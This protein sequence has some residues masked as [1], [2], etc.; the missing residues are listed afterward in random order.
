M[1]I[2]YYSNL[3]MLSG[4]YLL[5]AK[6]LERDRVLK[7]GMSMKLNNRLYDYCSVYKKPYYLYNYLINESKE[8]ILFLEKNI[9]DKTIDK[10][11]EDYSTEYRSY[12]DIKY[13]HNLICDT[14]N[15]YKIDFK[16]IENPQYE[17]EYN[18]L[19]ESLIREN[20]LTN[21]DKYLYER[22]NIQNQYI[23]A[24]LNILITKNKCLVKAPTGF[25]KTVLAFRMINEIKPN[26]SIIL[27]PRQLLNK[28]IQDDKYVK[29]LIDNYEFYNYSDNN[30]MRDQELNKFLE[31][32]GKKIIISCY[33]SIEQLYSIINNLQID[34]IIFDEAHTIDNWTN[35]E[36]E[37]KQYLL[38]SNAKKIFFTATPKDDMILNKNIYGQLIEKVKIYELINKEI[39]CNIKTV[40]KKFTH[41]S[42]EIDMYKFIIESMYKYNKKKGIIYVNSQNNAK[43]LYEQFNKINLIKSFI[44]IS[45]KYK[46]INIGDD[47][48]KEFEKYNQPC[49]IITCQKLSYG[50]DNDMIDLECFADPR[51]SPIEIRQ[52]IGRGI[53]W[54]KNTYPNKILHV[55]LPIYYDQFGKCKEFYTIK[56]YLDYIIGECGQEI[57]I[58]DS[59][60][61]E[62]SNG[63]KQLG[64]KSYEGDEIPPE[65]CEEYC[66]TA[67]N[68]F[69]KFMSFL[70]VN[71]GYNRERY[72]KLKEKF[73]WMI[74]LDKIFDKYPLFNFKMIHP[75]NNK[76]YQDKKE[77][78]EK[79]E[80]IRKELI[81]KYSNNF[82]KMK[83][84]SYIK[85]ITEQ[86]NMIPSDEIELYY[87]K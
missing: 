2:I 30:I 47:D 51:Q 11:H 65:I 66:T 52:I 19:S 45:D 23:K 20:E 35:S 84:S 15:E 17:R 64:N 49:I 80:E 24:I 77:C 58:G 26:L 31:N 62:L 14:L 81:N 32:T 25:G 60:G 41:T 5:R 7:I 34:L 50:Y 28:Q 36:S 63:N 61:F 33:Q 9:L 75:E 4:L 10:H 27:T 87:G 42:N 13:Y 12:D 21:I 82:R 86:D 59:N 3:L 56:E 8:M 6:P 46:T 48:I 76:F 69:S 22:I 37:A 16:I 43:Q 44:F 73:K 72:N 39:L 54:N 85:M 38:K 57:I 78:T 83:T 71:E 29:Q 55:L 79:Y 1:N 18:Y 67:Y 40:V 68:M 70:K 74:D 53:R